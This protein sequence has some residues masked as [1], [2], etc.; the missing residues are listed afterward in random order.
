MVTIFMLNKRSSQ[1]VHDACSLL[2]KLRCVV[3]A[4]HAFFNSCLW[5][6]VPTKW[7]STLRLTVKFVYFCRRFCR[8]CNTHA[9]KKQEYNMNPKFE[10]KHTSHLWINWLS[11]KYFAMFTHTSIAFKWVPYQTESVKICKVYCIT[12]FG[13]RISSVSLNLVSLKPCSTKMIHKAR[14]KIV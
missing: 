6:L 8:Y 1:R 12:V 4:M 11:W 5:H 7:C 2:N 14:R 13:R 9:P 3:Y 10:L